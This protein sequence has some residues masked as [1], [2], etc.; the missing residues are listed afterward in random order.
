MIAEC[1]NKHKKSR[2]LVVMAKAPL[3]GSVKTRLCP[4]LTQAE[5]AAFYECLLEDTVSQ[6]WKFRASDFW[7][8]FA[9]E[10]EE[11]FRR[12]FM[13]GIDLLAQRGR[14]LGERLHHVFVDLFHKGYE[15][16]VV[17]GS[18][19]PAISLSTIAQT[20]E[21]LRGEGCDVVL[22]PSS[23]GGYYAIG[24]KRPLAELFHQIPWSTQDTLKS[25][26][27]RVREL[28]L[29]VELL[30]PAYDIDVEEDLWRLWKDFGTS[31]EMKERAPKTYAY[32]TRLLSKPSPDQR[33]RL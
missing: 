2:A 15:E 29:K 14:D 32:L 26:L 21:Q 6:L 8:A 30:P 25:T 11:Y 7:I 22:G 33:G 19:S 18:D 3:V 27:E 23:D 13:K 4:S 24:L 28:G 5:A 10:G 16:I 1:D 31:Q 17:V 9:P 20:Y 12:R